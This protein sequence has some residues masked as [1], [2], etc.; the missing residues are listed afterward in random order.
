[1][2]NSRPERRGGP[3]STTNQA[4]PTRAVADRVG[5]AARR[6]GAAASWIVCRSGGAEV[7]VP[8]LL[9]IALAGAS[10]ASTS[11]S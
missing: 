2:R 9:G 3:H 8:L 6:A 1:V 10:M 4:A 5:I 7:W 11:W